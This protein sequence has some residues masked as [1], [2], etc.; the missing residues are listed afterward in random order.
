MKREYVVIDE[1]GHVSFSAAK[2]APEKFGT[3]K[4]AKK[5]AEELAACSPGCTIKIYEL[6]AETKCAV[7]PSETYRKHPIEHYTEPKP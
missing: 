3:W 2:D 6:T 5:R 1:E 4:A 7:A